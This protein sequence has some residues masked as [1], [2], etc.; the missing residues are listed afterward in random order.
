M[1]MHAVD[2][3]LLERRCLQTDRGQCTSVGDPIFWQ[4][5][6][7]NFEGGHINK[8]GFCLICFS[9]INS[10]QDGCPHKVAKNQAGT[11]PGAMTPCKGSMVQQD[12]PS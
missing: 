1:T 5:V 11:T 8:L 6:R 10:T 3:V 9:C 4:L 2:C 7:Q 12:N